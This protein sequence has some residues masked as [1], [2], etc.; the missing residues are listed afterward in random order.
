MSILLR[1]LI[2]VYLCPQCACVVCVFV[3]ACLCVCVMDFMYVHTYIQM[4][5]QWSHSILY[6]QQW[7]MHTQVGSTSH[8]KTNLRL[9]SLAVRKAPR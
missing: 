5:K 7:I 1:T 3:C 8:D 2:C 9:V 4:Y 6:I